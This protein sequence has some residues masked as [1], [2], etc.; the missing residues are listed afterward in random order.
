MS[1]KVTTKRLGDVSGDRTDWER[2]RSMTEEEIEQAAL[3]DLEE[4]GMLGID[5]S[6]ARIVTPQPKQDIHIRID[7]EVLDWFKAQGRGYQTRMNAVLRSYVAAQRKHG[8]R[9]Q[10]PQSS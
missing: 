4:H 8:T 10:S 5:W 7:R 3:E 6:K 2:L 9:P 1:E